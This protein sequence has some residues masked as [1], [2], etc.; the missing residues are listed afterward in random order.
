MM[1]DL[2]KSLVIALAFGLG[3]ATFAQETTTPATDPVPAETPA[4]EAPAT[5]TP[6]TE[7]PAPATEAPATEAPAADA[8]AEP[9]PD[10]VGATYT[11]ETFGDWML[12]CIRTED[13]NDPC[14]MYQL[15]KDETGNPVA[16]ISLFGLPDGQ[17]AA[18]GATIM[19]PLETMLT[20]NLLIKVDGNEAKVYPFT[21][22]ARIGCF[23]R[24]GFTKAEIDTFKKGSK[25]IM[26]VVPMA[27]PDEKVNLNMSLKGFTAAYDAVVKANAPADK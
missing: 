17:Q 10:A 11:K 1:A 22:C 18:A 5:E 20:E 15:M 25:A 21:F 7:A 24:V 12:Q 26:T 8:P 3:S 13:G 23:A 16:D 6:A 9:D 19:T 27:A 4:T 14:Q 2:T